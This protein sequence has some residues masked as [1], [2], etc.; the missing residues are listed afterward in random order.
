MSAEPNCPLAA[1]V[2]RIENASTT[3]EVDFA[4]S[5]SPIPIARRRTTARTSTCR[6]SRTSARRS[7][8]ASASSP[9]SVEA[10]ARSAAGLSLAR[11]AERK[12]LRENVKKQNIDK[13]S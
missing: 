10:S 6:P 2:S 5:A 12:R 11:P 13:P 7:A 9:L 8:E 4:R 1:S 3:A